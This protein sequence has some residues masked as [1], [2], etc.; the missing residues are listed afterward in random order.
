[1]IWYTIT[2]LWWGLKF[3]AKLTD[4]IRR[5]NRETYNFLICYGFFDV[6]SNGTKCAKELKSRGEDVGRAEKK[7]AEY[8]R[9]SSVGRADLS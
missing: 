8:P 9:R 7:P 6:R 5:L 1:L 3:C 2:F 4:E